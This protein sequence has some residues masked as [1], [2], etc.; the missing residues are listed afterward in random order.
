MAKDKAD[1]ENAS[2]APPRSVLI[3]LCHVGVV[4]VIMLTFPCL[5][6]YPPNAL[7]PEKDTVENEGANL[8]NA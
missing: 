8:G 1:N 3:V 7:A 2:K 5:L 4:W 6:T